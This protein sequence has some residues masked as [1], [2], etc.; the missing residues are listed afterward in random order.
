MIC[1][2]KSLIGNHYECKE[3]NVPYMSKT[4][5]TTQIEFQVSSN[6][7]QFDKH[8]HIIFTSSWLM[9]DLDNRVV[10]SGYAR[11]ALPVSKYGKFI[12]VMNCVK[13][14]S[15]CVY[16]DRNELFFQIISLASS[17]L[18]P[19]SFPLVNAPLKLLFNKV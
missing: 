18:I 17:T 11:W 7:F 13:K 9:I 6:S 19:V 5:I 3:V 4:K 2:L 1:G 14:V 8:L 10:S 16:Q 12:I 15:S